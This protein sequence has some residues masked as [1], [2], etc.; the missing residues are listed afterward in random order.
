MGHSLCHGRGRWLGAAGLVLSMAHVA[1]AQPASLTVGNSGVYEEGGFC[2]PTPSASACTGSCGFGGA[3]GGA[4][5]TLQGSMA[6]VSG[7]TGCTRWTFYAGGG[8]SGGPG[9]L[10]IGQRLTRCAAQTHTFTRTTHEHL[11][12]DQKM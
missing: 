5:V 1:G 4:A 3:A 10:M 7:A 2:G 11:R 9:A 12:R 8:M 6:P